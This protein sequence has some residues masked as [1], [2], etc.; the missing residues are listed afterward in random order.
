MT[1]THGHDEPVLRSHRTRNVDNS[2]RY[3]LSDLVPGR[4][5]L[6][7]GCG[8]GSLTSDLARHLAPGRV[9]GL[10]VEPAVLAVARTV[11][12]EAG[13]S[14]VEFHESD[15]YSLA[16]DDGSFDI[17]HAHQLLQ[18]L[19][20]PVRALEEM[21]RVAR[22]GGLVA[23]RDVDFG[24]FIVFPRDPHL[25]RW[26]AMYTAVHRANGGDPESGRRLLA[27]ARAAG[28]EELTCSASAWTFATGEERD[29][30]AGMWAD[31]TTETRL[32][33][34]AE[35][36]GLASREDLTEMAAAWRRW[37]VTPEGWSAVMHGEIRCTA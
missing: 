32:G 30:W 14:N 8:P 35:E 13:V 26:L 2:A 10:D 16:Y 4:S 1:Y 3:L 23:A 24:T 21:A 6:D 37:A 29:H 20:H 22:P 31:R 9:V 5:L 25:E 34:R 33:T 12:A 7:V 15:A 36:L 19:E 18:H 17:V 28:L 11:A 27:W